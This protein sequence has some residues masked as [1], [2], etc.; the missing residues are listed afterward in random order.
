[1][2][3]KNISLHAAQDRASTPAGLGELIHR[4]LSQ[5]RELR[6]VHDDIEKLSARLS[7][8]TAQN[9]GALPSRDNRALVVG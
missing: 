3:T 1:M 7:H 8:L 5:V 6:E 9:E 2:V 4:A